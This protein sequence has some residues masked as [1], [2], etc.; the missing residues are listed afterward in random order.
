MPSV[1][2]DLEIDTHPVVVSGAFFQ[3][4]VVSGALG[5]PMFPETCV[6]PGIQNCSEFP[7]TAVPRRSRLSCQVASGKVRLRTLETSKPPGPQEIVFKGSVHS[8]EWSSRPL[9]L[10]AP[11]KRNL[12]GVPLASGFKRQLYTFVTWIAS[13][14]FFF[15]IPLI[16]KTSNSD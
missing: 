8:S 5:E 16:P 12:G 4:K 7:Y 1:A 11:K 10:E 13:C 6:E 3:A 14:C 15:S 9:A 2:G